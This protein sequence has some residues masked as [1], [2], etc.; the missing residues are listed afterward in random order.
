MA[1]VRWR[2]ISSAG[3]DG[4]SSDGT[5]VRCPSPVGVEPGLVS[6]YELSVD[7]YSL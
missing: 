7:V 1:R 6:V 2:F 4:F 3:Y 5:M